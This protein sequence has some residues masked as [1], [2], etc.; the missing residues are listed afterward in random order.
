MKAGQPERAMWQMDEDAGA[1]QAVG[2]APER[3]L[4]LRGGVTPGVPGAKGTA[5]SFN[6]V[7]GYAV[8]DIPAVDT[9]V[10]FS[11]SAW[12]KLSKMPDQAAIIAAQPGNYAPGFE[13]YYSKSYDRWVFNQYKADATGAGLVRAMAPSPGGVKADQWTHLV[14]VYSLGDKELRLYVDGALVGSTA[15]STPW[16]ARRGLQIGAGLYDGGRL[17]SFF[18]GAID[19]VQ[20]FEKPLSAGE[21]TRLYGK[22]SLTAGRP[23][24]AVF[25]MDEPADATQ[26][27]GKAEVPAATFVGGVTSGQ[28]GIAGRA[29]TLNGIDGYA[30]TK[31]P[32]L[33]NQRSFAVSAWAKLP[34]TKPDH[35]AIIAT[36]TS[37]NRPGMELYYSAGYDRWVVNHYVTDTPDA[38]LIRAMQPEGQTAYG[39]TWTHLVGVYDEV[40][41]KLILYVNGVKAGETDLKVNWYA[42]E[43]VQ[44][45]A[46]SYDGKPG[47]FFPGQ[48]DDVRLFD[49]PV[50]AEEVQQIFRQR[51]IVKGRWTFESASGSP[52][53]TPDASASG[54]GM[55]LYD[56]AE[57]DSG[58]V[59]GGV[60]LDGLK[61]YGE[62][63]TVPVDTGASFTVT[64]W[65][66]AAAVPDKGVAL[67]SIPGT[68]QD[69]FSVRYEPS[70]DPD[71]DPGRWRIAVASA[72]GTGATV[73]QVDNGQFLRPTRWTHLALVYDGF[74][75][76]LQLY[77]NGQ[78]EEV[79]CAD[80]DDTSGASCEDRVSW[81]D[82]V[83]S[84]KATGPMQL[85]RAMTGPKTWGAYWPGSVSD[86]WAFQGTLTEAQVMQL[87]A[88]QPGMAT[89]VPG[90]N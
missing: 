11:V 46:G 2:S 43:A 70:S 89:E 36:Q 41:G 59:D 5:V 87:A 28:A 78:L 69:A 50:G 34:K 18:P 37:T 21:V 90:A 82:D 1:S 66:Q 65:A 26:L 73:T 42:G 57:L 3:T 49:R 40:A 38:K 31:R 47:S 33:Y 17:A 68:A 83:L 72:D 48:I 77:V 35:A 62:T 71:R 25:P 79:G 44:I 51:P 12:A 74:T 88:G 75:K 30:T 60:N 86:V 10:G 16:D 9:S 58:R 64:A 67:L 55:K 19:E 22:Q 32:V 23:A 85:G 7:D 54:N 4:E 6:G 39:D 13:L 14:G 61:G 56:G 8:S 20:I 84:F 52:L 80:T 53:V 81:A 76:Q 15:Y 63:S 27:I 24:R 45:G 29:L